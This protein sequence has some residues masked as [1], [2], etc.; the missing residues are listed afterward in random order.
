MVWKNNKFTMAKAH[1]EAEVCSLWRLV[2]PLMHYFKLC[3]KL[4][5]TLTENDPQPAQENIWIC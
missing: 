4:I 5:T 1:A 2:L 3:G